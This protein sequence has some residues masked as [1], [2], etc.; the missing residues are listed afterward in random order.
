MS[1]KILTAKWPIKSLFLDANFEYYDQSLANKT[2]PKMGVINP[3]RS[4]IKKYE[5]TN[6]AKIRKYICSEL[7][8]LVY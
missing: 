7:F 6:T 4:K 5:S 2:K 3:A 1:F 8:E